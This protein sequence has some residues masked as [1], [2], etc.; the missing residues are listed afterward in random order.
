M[1]DEYYFDEEAALNPIK[2]MEAYCRITKDGALFDAG[3]LMTIL[4]Y[5]AEVII[6]VFGI[7]RK[8]DG[9]RRF[10]DEVRELGKL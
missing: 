10:L 5:Q 6:P 7:K 3:N 1:K 8:E 9:R 4:P 2:F